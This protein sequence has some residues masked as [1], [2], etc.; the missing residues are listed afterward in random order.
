MSVSGGR[1]EPSI[2]TLLPSL[3]LDAVSAINVVAFLIGA[4]VGWV[5]GGQQVVVGDVWR[6][7][8]TVCVVSCMLGG[9]QR[10]DC[11]LYNKNKIIITECSYGMMKMV[12]QI[13]IQVII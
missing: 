6:G 5:S 7:G 13:L 8:H 12:L 10:V 11:H 9:Q 3:D 2:I 1:D 4:V